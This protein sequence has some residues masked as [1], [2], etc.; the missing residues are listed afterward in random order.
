MTFK[1]RLELTPPQ[2]EGMKRHSTQNENRVQRYVALC[3]R[4]ARRAPV[5]L[6]LRDKPDMDVRG[7]W[8][9]TLGQMVQGLIPPST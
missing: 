4:V 6:E 1:L 9:A 2:E 3:G 8:R 7:G 5:C